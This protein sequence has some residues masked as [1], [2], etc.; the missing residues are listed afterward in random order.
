MADTYNLNYEYFSTDFF[1]NFLDEKDEAMQ[2]LDCITVNN[3]NIRIKDDK[4][5]Y[6]RINSNVII[7]SNVTESDKEVWRK[8][9]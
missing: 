9:F 6:H 4:E 7:V 8:I 3:E 1:Q 2:S 5:K